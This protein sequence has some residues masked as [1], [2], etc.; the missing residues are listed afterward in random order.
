MRH[1]YQI[2]A[3]VVTN[4][5]PSIDPKLIAVKLIG[6]CANLANTR[7][8]ALIFHHYL[9]SPNIFAYNALLKAFAQNNDWQHTIHYQ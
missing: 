2:Q 4:S 9:K 5:I 7:H 8:L 3:Q 6:A 1:L